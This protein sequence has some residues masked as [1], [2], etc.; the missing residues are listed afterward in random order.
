ME[1]VVEAGSGGKVGIWLVQRERVVFALANPAQ[2]LGCCLLLGLSF[3]YA[4]TKSSALMSASGIH[5]AS[6]VG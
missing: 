4:R 6:L 2:G 5:S 1:G 3:S